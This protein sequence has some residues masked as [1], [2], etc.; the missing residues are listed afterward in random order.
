M[1]IRDRSLSQ[2]FKESGV[3]VEID[4]AMRYGTPAIGDR[5]EE[6]REKGCR[7]ILL[8]ALYPQYS[9]TTTA[10]AYDKAFQALQ[11]MRWQPVIRTSPAYYNNKNYIRILAKS[12]NEHIASLD[13]EPDVLLTSFHGLP[14]RYLNAGDPYHCE[15]AQTS[16]LLAEEIGWR[17]DRVRL[18]FQS[19]FGREEW[20]QPYIDEE[21]ENYG[22]IG[23]K[24]LHV[25][26]PGFSVDCLETLEEIAMEGKEEFIA[27][28]ANFP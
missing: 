3:P 12:I 27:L 26:S 17:G 14:K 4:W 7:K 18:A 20:L 16:R 6:M 10:S 25:I 15:C 13:W 9:A 5:L 23:V 28:Q 8:L 22:K 24:K 2:R 21:I 1:C 19:R 11:K